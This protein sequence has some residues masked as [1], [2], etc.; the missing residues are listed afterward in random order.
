MR[1]V[2]LISFVILLAV[3]GILW[4]G[5][6]SDTPCADPD[7]CIQTKD[8]SDRAVT[9]A[10][11]AIGGV[12]NANLANGAVTDAKITGPISGAKLGAHT[13]KG[14]DIVDG[15]IKTPKIA[16]GAVTNEKLGAWSVNTPNIVDY[17]IT[18][19]KITS[20]AVTA[21]KIADGA[22]TDAKISGPI[23]AGKIE[24]PSNVINVAQSGGDFTSITSA[25]ASLP[26]P[27]T[28]PVLIRVMP[29]TYSEGGMLMKSN[30]ALQGAGREAT[31]IDLK[32]GA[33]L[34]N[35]T[36]N[37]SIKDLTLAGIGDQIVYCWTCD[38]LTISN[39]SIAGSLDST[40][41]G[42]YIRDAPDKN[43]TVSNNQVSGC[44]IGIDVSYSG[45]AMIRNNTVRGNRLGIYALGLP[46]VARVMG[47]EITG[48]ETGLES[49]PGSA[50]VVTGNNI[51]GNSRYDIKPSPGTNISHNIYDTISGPG[52]VGMYNVKLDG[53]PAPLQ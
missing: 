27:N 33:L 46:S 6:A 2:R 38:N 40:G 47:N 15:T 36:V 5:Q 13:H 51:T 41:S 11:I 20:G 52:A 39:S 53:T 37:N 44:G 30:V 19:I 16:D 29:G 31:V 22:V 14:S 18:D 50:V 24:R 48:N 28:S 8:I 23:S 3:P 42:L 45:T 1:R 26:D 10:K 4:A 25:L 32:G 21:S 34:M 35:L 17:A 9:G 43:L 49:G 7:W 12:S